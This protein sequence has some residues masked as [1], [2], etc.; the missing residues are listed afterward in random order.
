MERKAT[1]SVGVTILIKFFVT[2]S[3]ATVAG[4]V[5]ERRLVGSDQTARRAM[6]ASGTG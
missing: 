2:I 4:S 3:L 1:D 5:R 6:Y